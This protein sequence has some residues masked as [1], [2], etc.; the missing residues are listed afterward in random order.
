MYFRGWE[1]EEKN[2]ELDRVNKL[3]RWINLKIGRISCKLVKKTERNGIEKFEFIL[4][5]R[6][7]SLEKKRNRIKSWRKR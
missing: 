6:R 2:W 5:E 3:E 4:I 1:L 7:R